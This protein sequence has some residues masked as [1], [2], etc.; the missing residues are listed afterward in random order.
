MIR[1]DNLSVEYIE[2]FFNFDQSELYIKHLTN[3][4]KWM[5]EKIRMWCK[6]IVTKKRI[7]WYADE[8]ETYTYS[9]STFHPVERNELLLEIKKHSSIL[10]SNLIVFY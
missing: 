2:N 6:E 9:G 7:A 1:A 10:I 5:R 8:G 3:D 4:I